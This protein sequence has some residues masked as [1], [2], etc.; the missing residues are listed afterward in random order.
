[1]KAV[2]VAGDAPPATT[3]R[4]DAIE[5]QLDQIM[6]LVTETHGWIAAVI[7]QPFVARFLRGS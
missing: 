3:E 4:L 6:L 5:R 7:R 1:M 2:V